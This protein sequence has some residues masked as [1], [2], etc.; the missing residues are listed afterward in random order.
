MSLG[1]II[2]VG[3]LAAI[4]LL[5]RRKRNRQTI[6]PSETILE[7]TNTKPELD[8]APGPVK[9]LGSANKISY[10]LGSSPISQPIAELSNDASPPGKLLTEADISEKEERALEEETSGAYEAAE[11]TY[12]QILQWRESHQGSEHPVTLASIYQ[13]VLVLNMCNKT[14]Q[15]DHLYRELMQRGKT[16]P[17]LCPSWPLL[18]EILMLQGKNNEASA[19]KL[20]RQEL[21]L[22]MRVLGPEHLLTLF[23][24][25]N[26]ANVIRR[27]LKLKEAEEACRVAARGE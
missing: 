23:S 7:P 13:L 12:R 6:P 2:L 11:E 18:R 17:K 8:S 14:G 22:N 10:E 27:Q 19:E 25:G 9:E 16:L 5:M 21:D 1:A 20:I 24:Q 4:W 3:L 26:L 15:D